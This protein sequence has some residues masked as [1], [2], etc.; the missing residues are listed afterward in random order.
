VFYMGLGR[1]EHIVDRLLEHGA[2]TALPAALIGQGT[3]PQQRVISATLGS[4]ADAVRGSAI[5]SPA[6][7][8]VGSVVGLQSKLEWFRPIPEVD[9]S[10]SA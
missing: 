1:L 4:I 10:R 9:L 7:L 5:A 3:L 2:A 6:L 8:V